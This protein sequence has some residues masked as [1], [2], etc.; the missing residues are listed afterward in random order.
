MSEAIFQLN[1]VTKTFHTANSDLT[2]LDDVSLT[3]NKGE[4]FGI[5][6]MSGAG[7]STLVRTLNQLEKIDSGTILYDGTDMASLTPVQLRSARQTIAMIFQS[8]NLLMQKTVLSNVEI[9]MKIAK[10]P[11]KERRERALEMLKVVGLESK[12][13]NY[14]AELS[15]GQKQRVAIA[16]ALTMNPQVLLCDEA[17]SALD[18]NIT[19]EILALLKKINRELGITVIVITHE[20]TVVETICD[21]VAIIE[22]GRIEEV[23]KVSDIFTNPQ[24]EATRRLVIPDLKAGVSFEQGDKKII[25]IVF[26]GFSSDEPVIADVAIST[27][28]K[29]NILSANTKS[30]NGIGYGQMIVEL[31]EDPAETEKVFEYLDLHGLKYA[32]ISPEE[33]SIITEGQT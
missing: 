25:R 1:N 17:T 28:A 8:F 12:A 7:K 14:P 5:I 33:R 30:V 13:K 11:K 18:P 10:I 23:G 21:R 31:P 3:I 24:A 15:G 2:A 16:R 20:M 4:I 19:A 9:A 27:G 26:D 6:G 32:E 29:L 22:S